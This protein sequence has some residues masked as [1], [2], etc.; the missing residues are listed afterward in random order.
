MRT[1]QSTGREELG[2][3]FRYV[4]S[5]APYRNV[6]NHLMDRSTFKKS[7][8]LLSILILLGWSILFW[9][10]FIVGLAHHYFEIPIGLGGALY[11]MFFLPPVLI[12]SAIYQLV[13]HKFLNE[14]SFKKWLIFSIFIPLFIIT[15]CLVLF[16]PVESNQSFL[17]YWYKILTT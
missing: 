13:L 5:R 6:G 10:A 1:T 12:G 15:I 9:Q 14:F 7:W 2:R 11:L 16:C 8:P 4:L 17:G 3:L